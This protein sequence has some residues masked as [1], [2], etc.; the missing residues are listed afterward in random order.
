MQ[1]NTPGLLCSNVYRH[2]NVNIRSIRVHYTFEFENSA[3]HVISQKAEGKENHVALVENWQRGIY[4][5]RWKLTGEANHKGPGEITI[6]LIKG[7]SE[8]GYMS[9]IYCWWYGPFKF[10]AVGH[11]WTRAAI[12]K[13]RIF[14]CVWTFIGNAVVSMIMACNWTALKG[15]SQ[16]DFSVYDQTTASFSNLDTTNKVLTAK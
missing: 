2:K 7:I 15:I 8:T 13:G 16:S 3:S 4:T 11:N 1:R 9:Y 10:N 12:Y 5:L 6:L 14:T